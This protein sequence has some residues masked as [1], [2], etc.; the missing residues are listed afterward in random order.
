MSKIKSVNGT[1]SK[2]SL[3]TAP[4]LHAVK[5]SKVTALH[6]VAVILLDG[7]EEQQEERFFFLLRT[8]PGLQTSIMLPL[9][10]CVIPYQKL[11]FV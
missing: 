9:L 1:Y 11:I 5:R 8:F 2:V 3:Q 4:I 7:R 10:L 6:Y